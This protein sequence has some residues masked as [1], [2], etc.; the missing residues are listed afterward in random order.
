M[1]FLKVQHFAH[2]DVG[3]KRSH[4]QDAWA[5]KPAADEANYRKLG[6]IFI[7]A[8]GMGGHAVG[9]KASAKAAAD[10][11]LTYQ[12]HVDQEGARDAIRRAFVEANAGIY[13]IGQK[14]PEFQGMGT[15]GTAMFLRSEGAWFGHVGDSRAYRIRKGKLEQ[16]TFDHSWVWEIAKR[17]GIDPDELGDFKKNVIIRSLGPDAE[18]EVDIEGPYPV[19]PGDIFLLCSDGLSNQILPDELGAVASTLAPEQACR[20]L[21]DLANVRGG[22]D[23]ITCIIVRVPGQAG[24]AVVDARASAKAS[25]S[26]PK[27]RAYLE[28]WDKVVPWSYTFLAL[29]ILCGAMMFATFGRESKVLSQAF[30]VAAAAFVLLGIVGLVRHLRTPQ[31]HGSD[32]GS[33]DSSSGELHIYKT[34]AFEIGKPIHDRFAELESL[35]KDALTERK[36]AVDWAAHTKLSDEATARLNKSEHVAAFR[37]RCGALQLLAA[38]ASKDRGKEEAFQPNWTTPTRT[39]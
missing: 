35:L 18:V 12:K 36:G 19:E 13:E 11:P 39:I 4:N 2:T 9:E 3:V 22:P 24:E 20:F 6:H 31:A 21:I 26:I 27:L 28:R 30:F 16:L 14:N 23:N 33:E 15:T 29:G 32:R 7:V 5:T 38:V 25:G 37:A 1:S 8:D 34:Y 10:I 17:Q